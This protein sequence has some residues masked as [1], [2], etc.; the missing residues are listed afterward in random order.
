M[1]FQISKLHCA[2]KAESYAFAPEV[3]QANLAFES[4][5]GVCNAINIRLAVNQYLLFLFQH[6]TN[7]KPYSL[8]NGCMPK[9]VKKL[10]INN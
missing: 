5:Y 8:Y 3:N 4:L 2:Y 6:A 7:E 9:S 10:N 1:D